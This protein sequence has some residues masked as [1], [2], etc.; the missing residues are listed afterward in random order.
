MCNSLRARRVSRMCP[1][2]QM[3]HVARGC[4]VSRVCVVYSATFVPHLCVRHVSWIATFRACAVFRGLPL[5]RECRVSRI[6]TFCACPTFRGCAVFGGAC[7]VSWLCR[8]PWRATFRACAAFRACHVLFRTC[9]H[10]RNPA[11]PEQV[12]PVGAYT[13][14]GCP[15]LAGVPARSLR[16]APGIGGE[17]RSSHLTSLRPS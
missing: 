12:L 3:S 15:G 17:T 10:T 13:R 2:S 11:H 1:V 8:V 14:A 9:L 6:A 16:G 5:S 7:H 4:H